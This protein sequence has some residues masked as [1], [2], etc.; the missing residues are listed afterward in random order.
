MKELL[1]K[2]FF[3]KKFLKEFLMI[4]LGV[5]CSAFAFSFFLDPNNMV[6]GGVGG[7]GTILSNTIF[8]QMLEPTD[9]KANDIWFKI[10]EPL[11]SYIYLLNIWQE[12][13]LVPVGVFTLEG[14]EK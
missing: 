10:L 4:N 7:I 2:K 6:C 11:A 3:N 9:Y 5:L 12:T 1:K 13:N 8:T 14:G